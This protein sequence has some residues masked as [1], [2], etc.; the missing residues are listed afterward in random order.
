MFKHAC[1]GYNHISAIYLV[2]LN[3][4]IFLHT[5][6]FIQVN[7]Y[8]AIY[9]GSY[10]VLFRSNTNLMR[11]DNTIYQYGNFYNFCQAAVAIKISNLF[12]CFPVALNCLVLYFRK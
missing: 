7:A 5:C 3:M 9:G 1:R 11:Q 2:A 8:T 10:P 6:I 4:I 12:I